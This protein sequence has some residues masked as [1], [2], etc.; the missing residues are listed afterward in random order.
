MSIGGILLGTVS[1]GAV[2]YGLYRAEYIDTASEFSPIIGLIGLVISIDIIITQII[3]YPYFSILVA[4]ILNL[5]ITIII[6]LT[7]YLFLFQ[8]LEYYKPVFE[9]I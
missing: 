1:I 3:Y 4:S 5:S 7:I 2:A 9:L 6:S 8:T